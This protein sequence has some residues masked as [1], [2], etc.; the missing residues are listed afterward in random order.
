MVS[1]SQ[2]LQGAMLQKPTFLPDLCKQDLQHRHQDG[3]VEIRFRDGGML[4]YQ[5]SGN[6][7]PP[8]FEFGEERI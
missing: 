4:L 5:V 8:A 7:I 2:S 6:Q 1:T 3:A